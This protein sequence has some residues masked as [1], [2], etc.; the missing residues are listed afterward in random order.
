MSGANQ[1]VNPDLKQILWLAL[2]TGIGWLVA[3]AQPPTAPAP[4]MIARVSGATRASSR[5]VSVAAA[6]ISGTLVLAAE[7]DGHGDVYAVNPNGDNAQPLTNDGASRAPAVSRNRAQIAFESHRDGNWEIYTANADGSRVT[8]LTRD[9]AFDGEPT[10]SPDGKQIAFAST[11]HQDLDIW[12]MNADG[13][14]PR[15]LTDQSPAADFAP[16]WSPD[17]RWI[18]FT[19]WRTGVAQIF[20]VSPD[21]KRTINL[22][23]NNFDDQSPAWSPDGKQLAFV[24]DRSGQRAIYVAGFSP[25][26]LRNA[27]RL[28]YSGWD[29]RPAWSPD[30]K[31]I[32]FV[33]PRPTRQPL[34][35]VPAKGGIPRALSDV[36]M[37]IRS[38]AWANAAAPL[39][40]RRAEPL[41]GSLPKALNAYTPPPPVTAAAL[42]P[43][44]DVYLAPSYGEMSN[45]V[46]G[47]FEALRARVKQEAGW[48]FLGAL[49][50]MTRQLVVGQCGDGCDVL[51]WHKSGRAVDT[52]LEVTRGGVPALEIVREDRLGETYWRIYLRAAAQ[53]G[54]Q[55]APLTEPP[56]DWTQ[57]ARWQIAPYQGGVKKPIPIGY[58]VDFTE[59]A[60]AY[61][62]ERISSYD[63]ATLSWKTNAAGM[64]FWHYQRT[65][66]LVWYAALRELYPRQTLARAFDWNVLKHQ[67]HDEYL[68]A[69]KR[70][71]APPN[72]WRWVALFR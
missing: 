30:G 7:R 10:W 32:A 17:G 42:V 72:A 53:D 68:L 39:A 18:A 9:L 14:N 65:D 63:D 8:R 62:W 28:T 56:W 1:R 19:S 12:V 57:Q 36:A 50:D 33:S 23:H 55:G 64:E 22:S 24:S 4:N 70:L 45:Q 25:T 5:P 16:A 59:L 31:F 66:G 51:S 52:R 15:D 69:L 26:G 46:S 37:Q 29:D 44:K 60:R 27:R 43:L 61:G 6:S 11:R 13:T 54:T 20:I 2:A 38:V 67:K 47:S 48:D 49:S 71:P 21:G 58:Y 40:A 41:Q 35:I 3:C 34:Y